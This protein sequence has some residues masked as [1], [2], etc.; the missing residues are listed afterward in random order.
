[1]TKEEYVSLAVSRYEALEKLKEHDNFYDYEK[2]F[3]AIWTDLGRQYMESQLNETSKTQDRRKKK[4]LTKYGSMSIVKTNPYME[5]HK[6]GFGI[7]PYMQELMTYAGHLDCYEKGNEILQRFLSIEVSSTQIYRVTNAVSESLSSE[8]EST[9]RILPPV[10]SSEVLYAGVDGSMISTREEGWKEVKLA[11]LFRSSDCLNP[12]TDNFY[13]TQSQYIAHFGNSKDF[14]SKAERILDSYGHLKGQLVFLTD[15]ATWIKNWIE[16]SYSDSYAILDY[17]HA[18]EHLHNFVESCFREDT[19]AGKM[20]FKEQKELLYESQVEQV[21]TNIADSK[22]KQSDKDK[23][24]S[25]Y[26]NNKDRMDY[27]KYRSVGCGIIGSGSIESAHRTVIQKRMK[28][29]GQHWS[30][31]GTQNMLRLRVLAMNKQWHKVID[32]IKE[33]SRLAA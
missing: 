2:N 20:W 12:N 28:L 7:S 16:D 6:Q 29:S 17:F 15:G 8:D 25:Y 23:L 10:S 18:C 26:Q 31:T 32:V 1:M 30:R 5:S 13:L 19:E 27:K 9:E 22:A 11:R 3:D 14:C 4:T 33:P 21:I 24:I